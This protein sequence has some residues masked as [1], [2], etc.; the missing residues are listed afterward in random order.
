MIEKI[1]A[2]EISCDLC[3]NSLELNDVEVLFDTE[4]EAEEAALE[5]GWLPFSTSRWVCD[6]CLEDLPGGICDICG[7]EADHLFPIMTGENACSDCMK[8]NNF[9]IDTQTVKEHGKDK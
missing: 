6:Q 7:E 1:S 3:G 5:A 8:K 4:K 2:Y 9:Y